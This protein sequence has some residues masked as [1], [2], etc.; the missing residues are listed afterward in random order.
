LVNTCPLQVATVPAGIDP[1]VEA[2]TV[3][4]ASVVSQ[5]S[6]RSLRTDRIDMANPHV[7]ARLILGFRERTTRR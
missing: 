4:M 3:E 6:A 1:G 2:W 5:A 7:R